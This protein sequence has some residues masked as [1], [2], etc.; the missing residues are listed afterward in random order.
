M[1]KIGFLTPFFL[2]V[3]LS[4]HAGQ[5]VLSS[6]IPEKIVERASWIRSKSG[7]HTIKIHNTNIN[8]R[9]YVRYG[10][11]VEVLDRSEQTICKAEAELLEQPFVFAEDRYFYFLS[12]DSTDVSVQ[13]LDLKTCKLAW[14]S[15]VYH[16]NNSPV[17]VEVDSAL[18][19][20]KKKVP[21]KNDCLPGIPSAAKQQ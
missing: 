19:L 13:A 6:A 5:C 20:S 14:Q 12:G 16:R 2:C 15:P 10:G 1:K 4:A 11:P 18:Y 7:E 3:H 8:A 21:L 9:G 17:I